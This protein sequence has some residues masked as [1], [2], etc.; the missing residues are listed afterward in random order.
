MEVTVA[1]RSARTCR[2]AGVAAWALWALALMGL[3]TIPWFDWLARQAGRHELAQLSASTIP[4]L[5]AI[6]VAAT[7]GAVVASRRPRHPVGWL[8]LALGLSVSLNGL[9]EG[10]A[11]YG[12]VA[13]PGRCRPPAT[14][15]GSTSASPSSGCRAPASSCC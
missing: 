8:L 12:V 1:G 2:R 14:W 11:R 15:P 5:L 3:A 4:D 13:R 9:A 7:V 10:Y 6:V